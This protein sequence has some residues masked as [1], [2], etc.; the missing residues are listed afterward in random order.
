VC[1]ALTVLCVAEDER[2]LAEL[3]RATASASWELAP[4][5]TTQEAAL[6]QLHEARPHVIVAFGPFDRFVAAALDAF[7][8]VR[9]VADRDLPGAHVV[10]GSPDEVR[11]AVLGRRSPGGPVR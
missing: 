4:G 2:S 10:V 8:N 1:R 9:V 11:D 3:K 5:A 7:P 6:R